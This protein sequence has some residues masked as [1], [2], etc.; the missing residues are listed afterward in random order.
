MRPFRARLREGGWSVDYIALTDPQNSSTA[1]RNEVETSVGRVIPSQKIFVC[2]ARK[3]AGAGA[4]KSWE[5]CF[6]LRGHDPCR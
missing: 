2:S 3:L 4:V 1:L 5:G 6:D